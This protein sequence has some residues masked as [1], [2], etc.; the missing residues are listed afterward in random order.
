VPLPSLVREVCGELLELSDAEAPGLVTGLYLIGSLA[1]GGYQAGRSDIDFLA[2]ASHR[3]GPAEVAALGRVHAEMVRR[4]RQPVLDGVYVRAADLS[5][6]HGEIAGIVRANRGIVTAGDHYEPSPVTVHILAT[7]GIAWRGPD[8]ADLGLR[9]DPAALRGSVAQDLQTY[10]V[11]QVRRWGR[12]P[13]P[14]AWSGQPV[15]WA[16]L[17]LARLHYTLTTGQVTTKE[18]AARYA[19]RRFGGQ[20]DGIL[21]EALRLRA[22]G[23]RTAYRTPM[24]RRREAVDFARMVIADGRRLAPG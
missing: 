4:H 5:R 10:W 16:V 14:P 9:D 6:P 12:S 23:R 21:D 19:S 7:R 20:W 3:P 17:G 1:L 13:W 24:A 2:V 15:Q 8:V 11:P 22:G 18:N